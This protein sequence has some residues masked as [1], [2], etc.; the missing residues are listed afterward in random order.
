MVGLIVLVVVLL[1]VSIALFTTIKVK[2]WKK[3][4]IALVIFILI[5]AADVIVGNIYFKYV[6]SKY[7]GNYVYKR[8]GVGDEYYLQ[9]DEEDASRW[10]FKLDFLIKDNGERIN[11]EKFRKDYLFKRERFDHY[12]ESL[13]ISKYKRSI[14]K[15]D[16]NETLSEIIKFSYGG[17]WVENIYKVT[18]SGRGCPRSISLTKLAEKTFYIESE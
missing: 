4:T 10:I 14:V 16:T 17:G 12:F 5:P 1:Y 2:G 11:R 13:H 8:V 3:K 7:S 6:C 15:K 9:V 18:G